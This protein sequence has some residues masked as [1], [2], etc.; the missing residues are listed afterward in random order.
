MFVF[1][2]VDCGQCWVWVFSVL[3]GGSVVVSGEWCVF[4]WESWVQC[5][6]TAAVGGVVVVC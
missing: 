4:G 2:G 5:V 3:I 1:S 6:T